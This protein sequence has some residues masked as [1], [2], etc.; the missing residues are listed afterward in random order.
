MSID[1][2]DSRTGPDLDQKI[3]E[4]FGATRRIALRYFYDESMT[5]DD[6]GVG[7][8]DPVTAADREIESMLRAGISSAWSS[9]RVVGEEAGSTGPADADRVWYIDPIDGTKAF[10]TGTTGWGTLVGLVSGGRAVAGWLHQPVLGETFAAT[11]GGRSRLHRVG[12]PGPDRATPGQVDVVELATSGCTRLEDAKCYTTHPSMFAGGEYAT[13][14]DRLT[15]RVRMQRYGGDCYSYGLVAR[16]RVDLVVESQ[17][18]PY[19]IIALIP[20]IE[21]AGGV[22][23]G[24]DGRPPLEGGTVVAAATRELAEVA[25]ATLRSTD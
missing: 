24:P 18:N 17:L 22:V 8:F 19:D 7:S 20:I 21:G 6:K 2:R 12:A 9:D 13:G 10:L 5:A 3:L 25:W 1:S 16:G 11:A 14:F 4:L 23:T 15:G